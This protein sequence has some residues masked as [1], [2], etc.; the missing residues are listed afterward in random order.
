MWCIKIGTQ[1]VNK[2]V[3]NMQ[4]LLVYPGHDQS[5]QLKKH[6]FCYHNDW[7][8]AMYSSIISECLIVRYTRFFSLSNDW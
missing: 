3:L 2:S 6:V 7:E 1:S 5:I 4:E 8:R